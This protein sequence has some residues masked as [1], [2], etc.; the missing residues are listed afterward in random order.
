M[1][2]T[3][4]SRIGLLL[5]ATTVVPLVVAG[6]AMDRYLHHLHR[7]IAREDGGEAFQNLAA[8]LRQL[9]EETRSTA[10]HLAANDHII[11]DLNLLSR[12]QDPTDY[13]AL[14]YDEEKKGL[15][16]RLREVIAT[17]AATEAYVYLTDGTLAAFAQR[18]KDRIVLGIHSFR[19]GDPIISLQ[20][21]EG[22]TW[23]AETLSH[24]PEEHRSQSMPAAVT[25]SYRAEPGRLLQ[26]AR[27][28]VALDPDG[29]DKTRV[30]SLRLK[31]ALS[32]DQLA[33]LAPSP[34]L[35]FAALGSDGQ[36]LLGPEDA[37]LDSIPGTAP[38]GLFAGEGGHWT[39]TSRY[40]AGF[41]ALPTGDRDEL[42]LG[43]LF[44]KERLEREVAGTRWVMAGVLGLAAIVVLPLGLA[45][46]RRRIANPLDAVLKGLTALRRGDYDARIEV[47]G[48]K[49]AAQLAGALNEMASSIRQRRS[50]LEGILDNLPVILVLKDARDGR[51]VRVNRAGTDLLGRREEDVIGLTDDEIFPAGEAE[52]LQANDRAVLADGGQVKVFEETVDTP[53]GTRLLYSRKLPLAT[54]SGGSAYVLSIDEDIT[55]RRRDTERL[56][57]AQEI[58]RVGAWEYRLDEGRAVWPEYTRRLMAMDPDEGDDLDSLTSRVHP[59]DQTL[60]NQA[61]E[62]AIAGDTDLDMEFRLM[63][64]SGERTLYSRA[65][66]ER[67]SLGRP[68][69]LVGMMQDIT[70]LKETEARL[71][72]LAYHD[73]LTELPNRLH[74]QGWLEQR[75][76]DPGKDGLMAVLFMDL[77]RF[78]TI[79]DSLGHPFGDKLLRA[80]SGR[81]RETVP[82]DDFL[83]RVSG[84]EFVVVL[85]NPGSQEAIAT[86]AS[87]LLRAL[88]T[89][90]EV[91]GHQIAIDAG[92]GISLYPTD[93]KDSATL[94]RNADAAMYHAKARGTNRYQ[95]YTADL[96][97]AADRRLRIEMDLR[98]AIDQDQL[99]FV[100]QP[101]FDLGSG[102]TIGTETLLRWQH[103]QLGLVSPAEFIPVAEETR[104]ILAIG[105]WVLYTACRQFQEWRAAGFDPGRLAI[106]I[107]P[108][109]VHD[110]GLID[111]VQG[112]LE[113][114]GLP[115]DRL[116]LEVTEAIFL[117]E[118]TGRTFRQL[119][120]LGVKLSVDDFGTGFSSLAYLKRLPVA[121]LK[122]DRSFIHDMLSDPNDRTIVRSVIALGDSLGLRVMAEGVETEDQAQALRADGCHEAQGFLFH[123]PLAG[124]DL[125][126]WLANRPNSV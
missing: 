17:T 36:R 50:E 89:P 4:G 77:D 66:L 29:P 30:G 38:P 86:Q 58:A 33:Q 96:T 24:L 71:D 113:A 52:V 123:H 72:Y 114:C 44:N 109:Q 39:E 120:E 42:L 59:D 35:F 85:H 61:L 105:E 28:P 27:Q 54:D 121:R 69:R 65:R 126:R 94:I 20:R 8:S 2:L 73:T 34:G 78:K 125:G 115:A 14:L 97:E 15:A 68:M 122:I 92:I 55:E 107:S 70:P 18:R 93:G 45:F 88:H 43:V 63:M 6:V 102:R 49:E 79:N 80:V 95:F 104:L 13:R 22:A 112:A 41:R 1:K 37:A 48:S 87:H 81:L 46:G 110:G 60:V 67:D 40:L 26:T 64:G 103:P 116:E 76:W 57:L 83:A 99:H 56:L 11:A 31:I 23:Q 53:Q 25:L 98:Q 108:A 74:L 3:L 82:P 19:D 51:Y 62:K 9:E 119:Q 47:S 10:A 7:D 111:T 16:R 32:P 21:R 91:E 84:D 100:Y 117:S 101:Q 12:Y 124:A 106:N 5:L 118:G 90:F 75:L